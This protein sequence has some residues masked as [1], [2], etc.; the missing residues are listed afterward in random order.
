M[1][2]WT[3]GSFS[4]CWSC[5]PDSLR[6]GASLVEEASGPT[7]C[8]VVAAGWS[9]SQGDGDGPG[10]Y[11]GDGQTEAPGVLVESGHSE[12]LLWHILPYL[13]WSESSCIGQRMIES[14]ATELNGLTAPEDE[15]NMRELCQK[16]RDTG[17]KQPNAGIIIRHCIVCHGELPHFMIYLF[18]WNTSFVEAD[19]LLP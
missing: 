7:T 19:F 18:I 15:V 2:V 1:A 12:A 11:L 8:L 4:W 9:A 13:S 14:N 6:E 10:I 17:W 5:S 16:N 3:C